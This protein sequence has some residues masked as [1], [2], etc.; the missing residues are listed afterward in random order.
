[1]HRAEYQLFAKTEILQYQI[2]WD[3][4][5]EIILLSVILLKIIALYPNYLSG[6]HI[7]KLE[8]DFFL[9]YLTKAFIL[10]GECNCPRE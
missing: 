2:L 5:I 6:N 9:K 10:L 7:T 1:M 8:I 4:N 3:I